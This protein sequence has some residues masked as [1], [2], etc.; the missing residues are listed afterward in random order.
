[1]L[2]A[3]DIALFPPLESEFRALLLL[4]AMRKLFPKDDTV[5]RAAIISDFRIA[6]ELSCKSFTT[7]YF[8][9]ILYESSLVRLIDLP[10][11]PN[12]FIDG[13]GLFNIGDF[14]SIVIA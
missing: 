10:D 13:L 1:M 2:L 6:V 7:S 9:S 12:L 14:S 8:S 5:M 4:Y 11:T 3:C